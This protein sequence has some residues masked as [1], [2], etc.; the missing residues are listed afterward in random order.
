MQLNQ[1]PKCKENSFCVEM[2]SE[3]FALL[4]DEILVIDGSEE[5]IVTNVKCANCGFELEANV[6]FKGWKFESD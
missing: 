5:V 6:H 3:H 2:K 1:C 4:T